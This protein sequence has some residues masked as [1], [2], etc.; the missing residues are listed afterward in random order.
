MTGNRP[1]FKVF[2]VE[3]KK[4][5]A[6]DAKPWWTQIGSAWTFKT[7]DGRDGISIQLRALPINDRIVLTEYTDEDAAEDDKKKTASAKRK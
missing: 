3:D 6:D 4:D 2:A 7:K 5:D 1:A